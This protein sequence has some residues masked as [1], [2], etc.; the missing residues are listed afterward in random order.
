M[1]GKR[2]PWR[3]TIRVRL[4]LFYAGAFFLAGAVLV[5]VMYL[6]VGQALDRQLTARLG[7]SEHLPD[8]ISTE[9]IRPRPPMTSRR[10]CGPSSSRIETTLWTPCSS[11][12]SSRSA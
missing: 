8:A 7:I 10:S 2:G 5:A 6:V 12:R 9:P 1:N 3:S 11:P 4:S